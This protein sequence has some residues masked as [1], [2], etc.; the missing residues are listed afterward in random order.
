MLSLRDLAGMC[1]PAYVGDADPTDPF[2]SPALADL[3]GLP[4][5][6]IIA[7]GAESLLSSAEQIAANGRPL[8][9]EAVSGVVRWHQTSALRSPL[10][11]TVGPARLIGSGGTR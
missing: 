11:S 9:A 6:L 1:G 7:G 8:R 2:V 3:H 10:G 4:H 5:L